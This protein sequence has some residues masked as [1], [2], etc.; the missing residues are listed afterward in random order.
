MKG[1]LFID[2]LLSAFGFVVVLLVVLVWAFL[3]PDDCD[4]VEVAMPHI[5]LLDGDGDLL[6]GLSS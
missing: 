2:N 4:D 6:H 5:F 1:V 3:A